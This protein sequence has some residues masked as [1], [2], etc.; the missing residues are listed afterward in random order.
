MREH[1]ASFEVEC[2]ALRDDGGSGLYCLFDLTSPE[3]FVVSPLRLRL[4]LVL[5]SVF[6]AVSY[7]G[8]RRLWRFTSST[9]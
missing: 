7:G 2:L 1:P 3:L 4:S 5:F 9:L 6:R 8:V